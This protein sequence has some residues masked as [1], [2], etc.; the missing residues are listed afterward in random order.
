[1]VVDARSSM[2]PIVF[3]AL[4][5]RGWVEASVDGKGH[6]DLSSS[7]VAELEVEL[8]ALRSGNELYDAEL[9]RR[10]D[11]R[12]HPLARIALASVEPAGPPGRYRLTG[13]LTV[14]GRT[15]ELSG[16][17]S[18]EVSDDGRHIT[19]VGEKVVDIRDFGIPA[20]SILMLKIYPD[21][22]IHLFAEAVLR[23]PP[24]EPS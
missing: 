2:G 18:V 10:I 17:A 3:E 15:L 21:V 20:P 1:M 4:G 13:A 9:R 16:T 12:T 24:D 14:H 11:A 19:V 8:S 5:P 7:P 22:R 6:V 23:G